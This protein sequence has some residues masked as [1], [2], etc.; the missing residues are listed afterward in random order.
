[1]VTCLIKKN[2]NRTIKKERLPPTP[3]QSV[4]V[5]KKKITSILEGRGGEGRGGEGREGKGRGGVGRGRE[6]RI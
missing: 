4:N 1:M 6:G 3:T 2:R 5:T